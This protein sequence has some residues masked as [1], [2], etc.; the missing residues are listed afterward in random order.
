M[1]LNDK[2]PTVWFDQN[3]HSYCCGVE[4]VGRFS[5]RGNQH[6]R[7][8]EV[9]YQGT[10][11]FTSTFVNSAECKAAYKALCENHTLL[12]Q[13]HPYVN[14]NSGRRVFLCVF[15]YGKNH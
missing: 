10:G 3:E 5:L 6:S 2:I 13:S 15:R 1:I 11:L 14:S 12:F 9:Q 8:S 7:Q 4:E